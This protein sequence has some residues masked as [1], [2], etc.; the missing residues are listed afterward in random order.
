MAFEIALL[1]IIVGIIL[2]FVEIST[3]GFFFGIPATVLIILGVFLVFV[4][5]PMIAIIVATL[6]VIPIT[7]GS[8]FLYKKLS[9]ERPPIP[10]GRWSIVGKTGIVTKE[11]VP[12]SMSGKVKIQSEI[13]SAKADERISVGARIKV[14][15][16]E[17]VHVTVERLGE[18]GQKEK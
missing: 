4:P 16:S 17:G 9:P 12:D 13:W 5:D 6:F 18:T 10:L 3:P 2:L 11:I 8:I 15:A 14:V 7:I 1:V